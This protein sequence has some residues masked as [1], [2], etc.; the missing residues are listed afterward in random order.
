MKRNFAALMPTGL[1]PWLAYVF[2]FLTVLRL[3]IKNP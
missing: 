3:V 2:K 1:H